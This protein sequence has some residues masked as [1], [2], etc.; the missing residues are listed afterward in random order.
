MFS[1]SAS[2]VVSRNGSAH[3]PKFACKLQ[4]SAGVQLSDMPPIQMLPRCCCR[5]NC[6]IR[7]IGSIL[8]QHVCVHAWSRIPFRFAYQGIH[9]SC[10]Q[11][12]S[13]AITGLEL[14]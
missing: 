7:C 4:A 11:I 5:T 14:P 3:V 12:D 10:R 1:R 13:D 2:V 9:A 8:G 6:R